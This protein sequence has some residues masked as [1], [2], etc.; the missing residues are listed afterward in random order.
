[1]K[2]Y[3]TFVQRP[4]RTFSFADVIK[5]RYQTIGN[6]FSFPANWVFAI[7]YGISPAVYDIVVGDYF[8][9]FG[10]LG[11][12]VD[13]GSPRYRP[14]LVEGWGEDEG[15]GSIWAVGSRSRILVPLYQKKPYSL[16]FYA[17]AFKIPN[18]DKQQTMEVLWNGTSV[19]SWAVPAGGNWSEQKFEIPKSIVRRGIN[20]VELRY[21]YAVSPLEL[22]LS[23]D[24]R[25]LS[26]RFRKMKI[27]YSSKQ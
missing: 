2:D 18:S 10:S 13:F 12:A 26:V 9:E 6:P 14:L 11:N 16:T 7:R 17:F 19:G 8:H 21:A 24:H 27:D 1:M 3:Y 4:N 22:G 20:E 15:I 5:R 25:R 23:G